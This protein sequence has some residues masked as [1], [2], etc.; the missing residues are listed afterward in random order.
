MA[1]DPALL[2]PANLNEK[3]PD[4]YDVKFITS[5]GDFTVRVTR[6][7]APIGSDRFYNLV[8]HG[9]FTDAA[10]FRVVPNFI[11]QFGL[12]ADPAVNSA[13]RAARIKDDPVTQSNK[14]GYITFAT[15]GPHTRT[16][17]LFINF[18]NNGFLDGQGFA[19]FGQVTA[20]M[21]I[22]QKLHSGYGEKPDQGAITMQGKAYL[23][24]N[25]P[26]LDTIKS[27][28]VTPAKA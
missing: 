6:A 28:V 4:V 9:Y 8:T 21:D 3:S 17:Q 7:W 23:D 12:S 24:K 20:G 27:A 14:P 2:Q 5:K 16:T 15:A 10:F 22:V 25:F 1:G 18:G 13:W 11:I 19:P 26:N